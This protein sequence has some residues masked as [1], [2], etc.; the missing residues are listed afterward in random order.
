MIHITRLVKFSLLILHFSFSF[1]F[2]KF[3]F[4]SFTSLFVILGLFWFFLAC[5][6]GSPSHATL[7]IKFEGEIAKNLHC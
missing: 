4:F 5:F 1:F 2:L 6:V 7:R 3:H